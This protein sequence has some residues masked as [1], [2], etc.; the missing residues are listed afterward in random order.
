VPAAPPTPPQTFT[1]LPTSDPVQG[2]IYNKLAQ[3]QA[4]ITNLTNRVTALEKKP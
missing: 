1:R 3:L 4:A 2:D